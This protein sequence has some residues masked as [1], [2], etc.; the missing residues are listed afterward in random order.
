MLQCFI[1]WETQSTKGRR[2]MCNANFTNDLT[3]IP[4]AACPRCGGW[5]QFGGMSQ[6]AEATT[7]VLERTGCNAGGTPRENWSTAPAPVLD[8]RNVTIE[9]VLAVMAQSK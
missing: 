6:H 2:K 7:P 1:D 9:D 4:A 3:K 8:V 5:T